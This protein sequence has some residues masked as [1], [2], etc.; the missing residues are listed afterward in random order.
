MKHYD[1]LPFYSAHNFCDTY[2]YLDKANVINYNFT[3]YYIDG[4][5]I[6]EQIFTDGLKC[7]HGLD[8]DTLIRFSSF[9]IPLDVYNLYNQIL[10][11]GEI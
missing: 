3:L 6:W 9:I 4:D 8:Y 11:D 1:G 7:E 10:G 5:R 2:Q